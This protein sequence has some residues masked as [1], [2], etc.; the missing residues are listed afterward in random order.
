MKKRP[1]KCNRLYIYTDSSPAAQDGPL[2]RHTVSSAPPQ[3]WKKFNKINSTVI[4]QSTYSSELTFENVR[5]LKMSDFVAVCCSVLRCVAVCC[6]VLRCVA[7][8][9]RVLPCVAVCCSVLQCVAVC[10][11]CPTFINVWLLFLGR[12]TCERPLEP[13]PPDGNSHKS[14]V[15][16]FYTVYFVACWLLRISREMKILTSR[17][18]GLESHE[19]STQ[20]QWLMWRSSHES[21]IIVLI[22]IVLVLIVYCIFCSVLTCEK[23]SQVSSVMAVTC[24]VLSSTH[25]CRGKGLQH[26]LVA[27]K[28]TFSFFYILTNSDYRQRIPLK[29]TEIWRYRTQPCGVLKF[30]LSPLHSTRWMTR[31]T[32]MTSSLMRV[33]L[34]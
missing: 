1:F 21:V 4:V 11:K 28:R 5:L 13:P 15:L 31:V 14:A 32:L 27:T 7:V 29:S 18:V 10:W 23:F 6:G 20:V 16:L 26:L 24:D 17:A 3:P 33:L 9:C 22:I 19:S 8:C 30:P 34:F 12:F 25:A 2:P